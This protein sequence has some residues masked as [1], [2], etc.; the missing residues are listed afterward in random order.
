MSS[1]GED[2]F[3]SDVEEAGELVAVWGVGGCCAIHPFGDGRLTYAYCDGK[4][5]LVKAWAFV[6]LATEPFS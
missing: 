2:L 6:E 1:D 5:C 3:F 4:G